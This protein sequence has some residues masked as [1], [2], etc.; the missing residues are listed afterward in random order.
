MQGLVLLMLRAAETARNNELITKSDY[1]SL[2]YRMSHWLILHP[3]RGVQ[4]PRIG[5]RRS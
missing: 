5:D 3:E 1:S 4:S 2:R